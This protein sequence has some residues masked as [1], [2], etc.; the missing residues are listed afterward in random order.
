MQENVRYQHTVV[1]AFSHDWHRLV[2]EKNVQ[3]THRKI[4]LFEWEVVI[5]TAETQNENE[6]SETYQMRVKY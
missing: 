2:R 6:P 4:E 3:S 1:C 5:A